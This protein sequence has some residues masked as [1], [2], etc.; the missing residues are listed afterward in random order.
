MQVYSLQCVFLTVT[1]GSVKKLEHSNMLRTE[2]VCLKWED[3]QENVTSAFGTLKESGDFVDV[4]LVCEDGQPVKAH[5]V[6]LASTSPFFMSIL[7]KSSH[8][9]PLI[10]MRGVHFEDLVGIV[11]FLYS[12]ETSVLDYVLKIP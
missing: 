10:Y 7:G 5:R 1:Q 3:F 6:I 2:K 8:P 12:G 9:Q 11:D 4:T